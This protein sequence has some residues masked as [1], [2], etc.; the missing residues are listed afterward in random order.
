MSTDAVHC[1]VQVSVAITPNGRADAVSAPDYTFEANGQ[2]HGKARHPARFMLPLLR[3]MQFTAFLHQ[4]TSQNSRTTSASSANMI[5]G[6]AASDAEVLYLQQQDNNLRTDFPELTDDVDE[7][8]LW[9]SEAFGVSPEAVNLWIGDDQSVTSFH[10]DHYEN[11]YGVVTGEKIF[12]LLPPCDSFRMYLNKY[13]SGA[14]KDTPHGLQAVPHVDCEVQWSSI[15]DLADGSSSQ[16]LQ[17]NPLYHDPALPKPMRVRLRPGE[18][19]FLPSMWWHQVEQHAGRDGLVIAVNY[20]YD[21]QFDVKYA[22][23]KL[24]ESMHCAQN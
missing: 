10:K 17:Q 21:M 22:Y 19:L 11:L 16:D 15:E 23:F 12:T 4:L 13:P 18:L 3:D 6:N 7:E 14:W 5:N 9:A 8:L 2:H 1:A 20:W 24:M